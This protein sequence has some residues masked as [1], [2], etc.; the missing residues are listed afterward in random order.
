MYDL[1]WSRAT[2]KALLVLCTRTQ[3]LEALWTAYQ[4][5]IHRS[6]NLYSLEDG[7]TFLLARSHR[8]KA[9]ALA[10]NRL[11]TWM[12]LGLL[13]ALL[14]TSALAG[15]WETRIRIS[16]SERLLM[17]GFTLEPGDYIL[18]LLN[19]TTNRAVLQVLSA[20]ERV[21]LGTFM[22]LGHYRMSAP[23]TARFA[24]AERRRGDPKTLRTLFLPGELN[25]RELLYLGENS[26]RITDSGVRYVPS[27]A[28]AEGV[29][30]ELEDR[31]P[32]LP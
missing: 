11:K 27:L 5:D 8:D 16:L 26:L 30:A 12:I 13:G 22:T 9:S 29:R 1:A 20:D 23:E 24:L 28:L 6:T 7:L 15:P 18:R 21:V 17:P 4:Q 2:A 3:Q 14:C 19:H 25:G 31:L 10:W 32:A